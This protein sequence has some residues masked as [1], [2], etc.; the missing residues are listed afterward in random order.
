MVQ[1]RCPDPS[2]VVRLQVIRGQAAAILICLRSLSRRRAGSVAARTWEVGRRPRWSARKAGAYAWGCAGHRPRPD[3]AGTCGA[4]SWRSIAWLQ[5]T[6]ATNRQPSEWV[7]SAEKGRLFAVAADIAKL[8]PL[9]LSGGHHRQGQGGLAAV[10]ADILLDGRPLTARPIL[11]PGA[12]QRQTR[13]HQA[14]HR[15][16]AQDREHPDLAVVH[17]PQDDADFQRAA[18][19]ILAREI[20]D[21]IHDV[22]EPQSSS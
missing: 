19:P 15:A 8:Q 10:A 20:F 18:F 22:A 9:A 14:R 21:A 7:E 5:C 13:V 16:P 3:Q 4:G 12:R 6:S 17:R 2:L 1:L 11:H